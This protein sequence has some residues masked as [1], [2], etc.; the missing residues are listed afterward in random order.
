MSEA[1]PEAIPA[2]LTDTVVAADGARPFTL[3]LE[4][5]AVAAS[6]DFIGADWFLQIS[7]FGVLRDEERDKELWRYDHREGP[8][9]DA[10]GRELT[11][12]STDDLVADDA[13]RLR[14]EAA[15]HLKAT[16]ALVL[17]DLDAALKE[18]RPPP[19]PGP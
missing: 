9:R 19:T 8:M 4:L 15:A 18:L 12:L 6:Q 14:S 1:L 17:A 5:D 2:G 13:A 10:L 7:V 3:S 11:D 16:L